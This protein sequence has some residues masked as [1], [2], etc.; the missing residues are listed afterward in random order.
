MVGDPTPDELPE[1][2]AGNPILNAANPPDAAAGG[3]KRHHSVH[4]LR[5]T[6]QSPGVINTCLLIWGWVGSPP[7]VKNPQKNQGHPHM[8]QQALTKP[9][10]NMLWVPS[11]SPGGASLMVNPAS[12]ATWPTGL[13]RAKQVFG[14]DLGNLV[15]AGRRKKTGFLRLNPLHKV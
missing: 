8:N 13:E 1:L 14:L 4:Q 9:G 11:A 6:L 15:P 5:L 7:K 12:S 10:V 2:F 3:P